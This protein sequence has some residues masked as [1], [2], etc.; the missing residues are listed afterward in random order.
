MNIYY[1]RIRNLKN[2]PF[3]TGIQKRE[4]SNCAMIRHFENKFA[5]ETLICSW[6]VKKNITEKN[7]TPQHNPTLCILCSDNFLKSSFM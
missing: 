2:F 1:W 4:V 5:V 3:Q 7:L 6:T